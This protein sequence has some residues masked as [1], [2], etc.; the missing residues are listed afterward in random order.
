[1]ILLV[2]VPVTPA[3]VEIPVPV[4]A[5]ICILVL[6]GGLLAMPLRSAALKGWR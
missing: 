1:M 2:R 6:A 5:P 3:P 4:K